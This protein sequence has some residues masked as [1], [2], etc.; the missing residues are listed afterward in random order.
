M[1]IFAVIKTR[2][3]DGSL[4]WATRMAG[5]E[6]SSE[7]LYGTLDPLAATLLDELAA[8]WG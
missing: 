8:G 4:S 1:A 2:D 6:V 7:E 5:A 3:V